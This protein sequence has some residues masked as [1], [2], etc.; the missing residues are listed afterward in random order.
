MSRSGHWAET[1]VNGALIGNGLYGDVDEELAFRLAALRRGAA[2]DG[3]DLAQA[4]LPLLAEY[5]VADYV[6]EQAAKG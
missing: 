3:G 5:V 6:K 1:A 4:E 2:Q